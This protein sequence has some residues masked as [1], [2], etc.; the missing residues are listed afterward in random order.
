MGR[1]RESEDNDDDDG[2]W[3]DRRVRLAWPRGGITAAEIHP[4]RFDLLIVDEVKELPASL[5]ERIARVAWRFSSLLLLTATPPFHDPEGL[6]ALLRA[7]EPAKVIAAGGAAPDADAEAVLERLRARE[8]AEADAA[9]AEGAPPRAWVAAARC[10]LRGM[11]RTRRADW[12]DLTPGRAL[13]T[14]IVEPTEAEVWRVALMW[15]Y[16]GHVSGLSQELDLERLA[17]RALRGRDSLRQRVTWLRGGAG[18]VGLG[19]PFAEGVEVPVEGE[20]EHM[21]LRPGPGGEQPQE[22]RAPSAVV[23]L[24]AVSAKRLSERVFVRGLIHV[25]GAEAGVDALKDSQEPVH[26]A[27]REPLLQLKAVEPGP[28]PPQ[29]TGQRLGE[30]LGERVRVHAEGGEEPLV[31]VR[32]TEALDPQEPPREALLSAA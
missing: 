16:L 9:D 12:P 27:L 4:D 19:E 2:A 23:L 21:R 13:I 10:G 5:Q 25:L 24:S 17:Q 26:L 32:V 29:L 15:R 22:R 28:L 3:R 20:R 1:D 30:A 8:A 18:P 7:L 11:I 14:R 6:L 31:A